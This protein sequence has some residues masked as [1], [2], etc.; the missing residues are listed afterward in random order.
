MKGALYSGI[1]AKEQ[2]AS[3]DTQI[4]AFGESGPDIDKMSKENQWSLRFLAWL[5]RMGVE[6]PKE[7]STTVE[8]ESHK[9][10]IGTEQV[11]YGHG[12]A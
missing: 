1:S 8:P 6:N 11:L 5:A 2:T 4:V 7:H 3:S 10:Q 9:S 12:L